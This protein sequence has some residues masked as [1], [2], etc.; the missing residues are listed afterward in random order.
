M[1]LTF[2]FDLDILKIYMRT[3]PV[4]NVS[5][6][7]HYYF[8][9]VSNAILCGTLLVSV[10]LLA[11]ECTPLRFMKR[12]FTVY[13]CQWRSWLQF[14]GSLGPANCLELPIN[15]PINQ[16]INQFIWWLTSRS[17]G[18]VMGVRTPLSWRLV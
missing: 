17:V 6:T 3:C 16:S 11:N 12:S 15:Q 4:A 13:M 9:S 2:E 10:S 18:R 14:C 7:Q 1:T 5:K 8:R